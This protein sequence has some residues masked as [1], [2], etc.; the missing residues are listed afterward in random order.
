VGSGSP[1]HLFMEALKTEFGLD[2]QHVPYKGTPAALTDLLAGQIQVMFA[3]A[4]VALPNIQAGKVTALGTS[5][6][7]Q[8]TLLPSVPPIAATVP[9]FDW[10]AWQGIVAPA[11]TPP[12]VVARLSA[13]LQRIQATP[14][15]R[16]QLFKFGMEPFAPHTPAEFA[17]IIQAEQP[18]WAKAIRDSGAKVD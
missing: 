3:D 18:R 5:A 6:A 1:H 4:T 12:E 17:A 9:G 11:G 8:T 13:E 7:K 16:E 2:I 15:F 14:E 10:Q